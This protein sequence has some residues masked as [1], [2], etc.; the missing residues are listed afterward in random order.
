MSHVNELDDLLNDDDVPQLYR[1]YA[2]EYMGEKVTR[3]DDDGESSPEEDPDFLKEELAIAAILGAAL[4][5]KSGDFISDVEDLLRREDFG[6]LD[7]RMRVAQNEMDEIFTDSVEAKVYKSVA[8]EMDK[9]AILAGYELVFRDTP[10]RELVLDGMVKS[11]KYYTNNYFNSFVV[12]SLQDAVQ[13]HFMLGEGGPEEFAEIQRMLNM[14]LKTV[15]YWRTVANVAASRSYH[16]GMLKAGSLGGMRGYRL[17]NPM[18][19]K[20]SKVCKSLYMKEF[21]LADAVILIE[22]TAGAADAEEVKQLQ[23]WLS[24]KQVEG[25]SSSELAARG[26]M[27]PPFHGLC[28]TTLEL[29]AGY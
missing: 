14:R 12:P 5:K 11:T 6:R 15:P 18:D 29:I 26:V 17:W 23:P 28:R 22:R 10:S 2:R 24:A 19:E 4:A 9:G 27:V 21:W 13:K 16:Y 20:T 3:A 1:D 7:D 25:L 8:A